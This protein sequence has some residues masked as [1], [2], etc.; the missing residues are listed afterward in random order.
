M[1][2]TVSTSP[3]WPKLH[4]ELTAILGPV[5]LA[6]DGLPG[7]LRVLADTPVDAALLARAQAAVDSHDPSLTAEQQESERDGRIA[8]EL[9]QT[10]RLLGALALR[11]SSSWPALPS[12]QKLVVQRKI[13]AMAGR[14]R[15]LLT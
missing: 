2:L 15:D 11:A 9:G 4:S 13:D 12:S 5:G 1:I 14:V 6:H 7:P 3:N 10:Q 8:D